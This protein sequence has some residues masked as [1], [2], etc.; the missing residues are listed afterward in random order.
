MA[1]TTASSSAWMRSIPAVGP[2]S[3]VTTHL[4]AAGRERPRGC[5]RAD[6]L[7]SGLADLGGPRGHFADHLSHRIAGQLLVDDPPGHVALGGGVGD[8]GDLV[9]GR[10]GD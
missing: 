2:S 6:N 10:G 4:A 3:I 9:G 1:M 7:G 5:R 8:L